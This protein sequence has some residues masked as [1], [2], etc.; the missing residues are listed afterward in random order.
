MVHSHMTRQLGKV[1]CSHDTKSWL[2]HV[3]FFSLHD[4][5][6]WEA[7]LLLYSLYH[8]ATVEMKNSTEH[9][10]WV[11]HINCWIL[12]DIF[13]VLQLPVLFVVTI[14]FSNLHSDECFLWHEY[15]LNRPSSDESVLNFIIM[16]VFLSTP[17][18]LQLLHSASAWNIG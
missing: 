5:M 16:A 13:K 11:K 4:V 8:A 7:Q 1:A 17:G 10:A 14:Y 9:E 12:Q 15:T 3:S 6:P 18:G 2:V